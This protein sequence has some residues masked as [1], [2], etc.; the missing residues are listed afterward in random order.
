MLS[1]GAN[2]YP[3]ALLRE[4]GVDLGTPGPVQA[5]L[6][7]M[8]TAIEEMW[9]IVDSGALDQEMARRGGEDG[10]PRG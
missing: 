2:D 3:L 4:A 6:Q 9:S 5:A 8:D 10:S 1:S 7:Q